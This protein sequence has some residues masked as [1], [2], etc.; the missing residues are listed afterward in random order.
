MWF[1][2]LAVSITIQGNPGGE[3]RG[4]Y[5]RQ[6]KTESECLAL[7]V[8][9]DFQEEAKA[10]VGHVISTTKIPDSAQVDIDIKCVTNDVPA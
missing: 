4:D 8:T 3:F 2:K 9:K 5:D 7:I 1:I 10:F 6:F